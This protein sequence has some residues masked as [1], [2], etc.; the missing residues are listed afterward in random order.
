[1]QWVRV[2]V[3]VQNQRFI[4]SQV[5]PHHSTKGR[6]WADRCLGWPVL[7][8]LSNCPSLVSSKDSVLRDRSEWET[9]PSAHRATATRTTPGPHSEASVTQR[10]ERGI[11]SGGTRTHCLIGVYLFLTS[12]RGNWLS[13]IRSGIY[14]F[15][16]NR[17]RGEREGI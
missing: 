10:M 5:R 13:I 17:Q 8:D 15:T 7:I 6:G 1:M 4:N 3:C 16:L 11:I 12:I 2:R 14:A 9:I